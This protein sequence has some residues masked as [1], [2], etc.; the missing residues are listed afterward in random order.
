MI[1]KVIHYCW[2]GKNPKPT[3]VKKCIASWK[4]YCPD[5]KIVEWNEENFSVNDNLYCSQAYEKGKW[6]FVSDYARLWIIYHY[7]GIY[8][9]TD[10]EVIRPWDEL[11]TH[12][13]FFGRQPGF[14]VNTG[15]G[16]GAEEKHPLVKRMLDDYRDIP[17]IKENGDMDLWTCPHRNSQWLFA[18]GLK[19]D[20][21]LQEIEGAVIYP[22]EYFS[23]KD[24]W[25]RNT[26]ITRNTFSIHHCDG[27]WNPVETKSEHAK[28]YIK[29]TIKN[30]FDL[31]VHIPNRCLKKMLGMQRYERL[32]KKIK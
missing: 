17:F 25:N 10:V 13:C 28:R 8:L 31:V 24:A 20:D 5:Y 26:V 30:M 7:G 11:L 16:F 22:I 1:P 23:P 19:M 14:Q 3:A 18:H 29:Y 21:S 15:V 27:T 2:F 9:D 6:A 4:K 32:K 12:R